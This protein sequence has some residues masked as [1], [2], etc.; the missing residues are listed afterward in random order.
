MI[1]SIFWFRQDLRL[2]DNPGLTA[3]ILAGSVLPVYIHDETQTPKLGGA[4]RWWLHHSLAALNAD[5]ERLGSRLVLRRGNPLKIM[6]SLMKETG[7]TALYLNRCYEPHAIARDTQLKKDLAA[8]GFEY[9][10]FNGSLLYEPWEIKTKEGNPCRVF[11]PFWKTC[12]ARGAPDAP[13]TAPAK[14]NAV[15]PEIPSDN[16]DDWHLLPSQPDWAGGLRSDWQVGEA[17]ALARLHDFLNQ[18]IHRYADGRDIPGEDNTS[19]LSPYLHWGQISPRQIFYAVQS[20]LARGDITQKNA[21]KF[22]AE[23]G[24]REFS[25]SLLY[26]NPSLPDAPLQSRFADFPWQPNAQYLRAW[27]RGQTGVPMV[28]AGMRELW[29]T[30]YMH[31]RVRMIAAS[32]LV[33]NLLQPWQ[34]GAAWFWDTLC[35]ADLA[36]NSASWQW[37]AGCGADA[38][39]YFRVFNPVLQGQKFDPDGKYIRRWIPE[40]RDMSTQNI[41]APWEMSAPPTGYPPPILNLAQSRDRALKA[42]EQ[43]MEQNRQ[44]T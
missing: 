6:P 23:I 8:R 36:S 33:K 9:H 22:L 34:D 35:D 38:A 20:A 5:L 25:Y 21:D 11:T 26:H 41:H 43:L 40:L 44:S 2:S 14:L 42:F 18:S 10:S 12:L 29:H 24:W 37:V 19:R 4:S 13:L 3:A 30:G 17:H 7:A 31:N 15:P 27:Q 32:F 39:P 28:D 1:S 16:L